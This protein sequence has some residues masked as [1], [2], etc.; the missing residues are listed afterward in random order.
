MNCRQ[1]ESYLS[2]IAAGLFQHG[3][4]DPLVKT[5]IPPIMSGIAV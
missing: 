2:V 3:N 1:G 4:M 5:T